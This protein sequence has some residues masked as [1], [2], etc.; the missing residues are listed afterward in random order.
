[1]TDNEAA[2]ALDEVL[3]NAAATLPCPDAEEEQALTELRGWAQRSMQR[4]DAKA[5]HL[6]DWLQQT[7]CPGGVW[8]RTRVV[9]FTEYMDTKVAW[10]ASASS[11]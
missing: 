3:D 8:N 2:E 10:A 7:L 6:L 9:I 5:E 4:R 11:A 1:M